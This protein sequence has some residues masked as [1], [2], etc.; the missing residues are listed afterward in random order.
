MDRDLI[1][2]FKTSNFLKAADIKKVTAL[3]PFGNEFCDFTPELVLVLRL[4]LILFA[5][6]QESK[7]E[8]ALTNQH[9]D[10]S[11]PHGKRVHHT[12]I[13]SYT[14]SAVPFMKPPP[15]Q[16]AGDRNKL[17]FIISPSDVRMLLI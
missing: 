7:V 6:Q 16:V 11:R 5:Q 1:R 13:E 9:R 4:S 15:V 2:I 12:L 14:T 10:W 8:S 17:S 3:F